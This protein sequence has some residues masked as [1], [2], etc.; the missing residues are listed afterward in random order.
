MKIYS[1]YKELEG[2]V[3]NTVKDCQIAEAKVDAEKA[4]AVEQAR[5]AEAT[6]KK[7]ELANA[8]SKADDAVA[9]AYSEYEIAKQEVRKILEES[10][11]RMEKILGPAKS[12]VTKAEN[13]RFEAI[14]AYN[15][16]FGPYQ[17]VYTGERAEKELQRFN[18]QFNSTFND[19]L[20]AFLG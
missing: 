6:K 5:K 19:L 4:Q 20:K 1:D 17:S 7:K 2:T 14:K 15:R 8:V 10:N 16:E 11:T 13:V 18:Q 9:K 3:F 12:A